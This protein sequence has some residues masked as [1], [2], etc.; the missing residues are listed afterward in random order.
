MAR[1]VGW[2]LVDDIPCDTP[3]CKNPATVIIDDGMDG[4]NSCD[5]HI[6]AGSYDA[7]A[8]TFSHL[9]LA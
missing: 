6:P 2:H 4:I 8:Q 1:I 5:E 9:N 3:E 7:I